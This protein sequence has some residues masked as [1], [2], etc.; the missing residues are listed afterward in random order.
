MAQNTRAFL[1][2][3]WRFPTRVNPR[4]GLSWS[5]GEQNI[6]EA[7][8]LIL[9][10]APGERPML[11]GFGCGMHLYVFAP[12]T[13]STRAS[14]AHEV[15]QALARW[16]PRIDVLDVRAAAP[17]ENVMLIAVDYRVRSTNAFGNLV[18]PFFIHEGP[19]DGQTLT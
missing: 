2:T 14:V 6:Q 19:D 11:P 13:P 9:A 12:N 16:E 3:G 17:E 1:G 18:Y 4:G 5:S 8:W 15:R 10:T 7:I